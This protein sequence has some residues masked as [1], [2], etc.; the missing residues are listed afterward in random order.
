MRSNPR[1]E[2]SRS[3]P[4]DGPDLVSR[5]L[6]GDETLFASLLERWHPGLSHVAQAITGDAASAEEVVQETWASVLRS[7]DAFEGR[8]TFRTW[9]H[10][11][12]AFVA[13]ARTGQDLRS[14]VP[15]EPVVDP[16]C[17]DEHGHWREAPG[18]RADEMP[19]ALAARR[20]AMER[21]ERAVDSLPLG[22]RLVIALRDVHGF[23]AEEACEILGVSEIDQRVLLHRGRSRIRAR[24]GDRLGTWSGA[25]RAEAVG[26]ESGG[27]RPGIRDTG[28]RHTRQ[29]AGPG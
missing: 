16:A 11:V 20:Q 19:V 27:A 22:Q 10:R 5:L 17:F 29:P 21:V 9:V 14:P 13:L 12:C 15:T 26:R 2:R 1:S 28:V 8:S 18:Y 24:L 23:S 3:T 4:V 25:P 6:G 7:L